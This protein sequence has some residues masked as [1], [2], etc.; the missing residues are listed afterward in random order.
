MEHSENCICTECLYIALTPY[1]VGKIG[2]GPNTSTRFMTLRDAEREIERI[3]TIDPIGVANG[4][5]FIN[6]ETE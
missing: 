3:M 1:S 4:E 6:G 5:Y 2:T